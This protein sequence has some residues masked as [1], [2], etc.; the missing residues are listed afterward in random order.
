MWECEN[1]GTTGIINQEFCPS[2]FTK[3]PEAK[4]GEM[5][6]SDETAPDAPDAPDAADATPAAGTADDGPDSPAE[7]ADPPGGYSEGEPSAGG[8]LVSD[9]DWG[10]Q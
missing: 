1:C 7:E 6:E 5:A 8:F 3:R 4:V 10:K 9:S 2:C